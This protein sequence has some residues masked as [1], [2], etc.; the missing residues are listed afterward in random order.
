MAKADPDRVRVQVIT[1]ALSGQELSFWQ[2]IQ[3]SCGL[4]TAARSASVAVGR[5]RLRE[6]G[7]A[8]R[9]PL[10]TGDKVQVL[11][12]DDP[13]LLGWADRI[14][15]SRTAEAHG[16]CV[17]IR[18]VT[19]DLVDCSAANAPGQWTGAK[20]SRIAADLCAPFGVPVVVA[21]GYDAVVPNFEL[22]QGEGVHDALERL[23]RAGGLVVRD[24][25]TGALHLTRPG[26]TRAEAALVH[27]DGPDGAPDPRNNVLESEASDDM[28][29]RYSLYTCKGQAEGADIT[30][31][32][33]ASASGTATD[34]GV[35]RYRP[36][37]LSP[38]GAATASDCART[39]QWEAARRAGK[40]CRL[41]HTVRGWRQTA[42]G[43]LWGADLVVPVQD[44]QAGIYRDLLTTEVRLTLDGQGKRAVV[45]LEPAEAWEPQPIVDKPT[46]AAGKAS[47][48]DSGKWASVAKA[49]KGA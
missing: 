7:F 3:V 18:S 5:G 17:Q 8:P 10:A 1:G 43:P 36:K 2:S 16:I 24:T 15:R 22:E 21:D 9:F 20:R 38:P 28:S 19:C 35:T 32:A 44:D 39:A 29:G 45:T 47:S 46:T 37:I 13:V 12:G 40:G 31:A 34:S 6:A 26:L 23:A 11:I 49:V 33:A 27:L 42:T 48:S 41:T 14:D 25:A 30:A 4:D